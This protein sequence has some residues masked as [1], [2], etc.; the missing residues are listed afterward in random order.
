MGRLETSRKQATLRKHR[1]RS[2]ITG[3]SSRPRLSVNISNKHVVAQLI[4]DSKSTTLVYSTSV[5]KKEFAK[6][7][8][9]AI[10]K[11]IGAD[12]AK[13]A[14]AKKIKS[15]VLDRGMLKYH[16]RIKVLTEAARE[17]GLEI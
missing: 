16:G 9:T 11:S 8:L 10:A 6:N 2:R 15:A 4:D 7:D 14:A 12:L 3:T 1:V 17:N 5:G 13:Q